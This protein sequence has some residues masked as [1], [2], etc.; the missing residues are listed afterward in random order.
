MILLR[1]S[2]YIDIEFDEKIQLIK[3]TWKTETSQMCR[4]SFKREMLAYADFFALKPVYV[5]HLM[6]DLQFYFIPELQ[7]WLDIHVN[8]KGVEAGVEKAAFI[9]GNNI[10][11]AISI[12]QTNRACYVSQVDYAY[13]ET[14]TKAMEWLLN[15]HK[16]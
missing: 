5:L 12:E 4:E 15:Q 16:A 10:I 6:Q 14:E 3:L 2:K 7:E 1:T 8:M 11:A 13:F 9:L